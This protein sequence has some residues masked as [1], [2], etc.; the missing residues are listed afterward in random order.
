MKKL[1]GFMPALLLFAAI[2][3]PNASAD[4]IDP[5]TPTTTPGKPFVLGTGKHLTDSASLGQLCS[6]PGTLTFKVS[7]DAIFVPK[8]IT[9]D[10]KGPGN[11]P[12]EGPIPEVAA[13]FTWSVVYTPKNG[14]ASDA[15]FEKQVVTSPE[16]GTGALML[17]GIVIA[18]AI[19]KRCASGLT[20]SR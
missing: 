16:P 20:L 12:V 18:L 4:S 9:V 5:C 17:L 19:W 3:A 11:Y 8:E 15:V 7:G 13:T 6:Y 2:G 1:L 14:K 10:V